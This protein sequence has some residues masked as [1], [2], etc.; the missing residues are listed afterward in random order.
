MPS[1]LITNQFIA[2]RT[3]SELHALTLARLFEG[4][5]WDVT[6][7]TLLY[8]YPLQGEFEAA[9]IR[10][11]T[12]G[13][14]ELLA[15]HYDVLFAQHRLAAE[16]VWNIGRISFGKVIV[17]VLGYL[18][19]AEQPPSFWQEADGFV[20]V[21]EETR[22]HV[23]AEYSLE[24]VPEM[25]FP[26]YAPAEY[27]DVTRKL[28]PSPQ[29]VCA[30]S[31][32]PPQELRELVAYARDRNVQID[33]FGYE[34]TS[35]EVTPGL[36][37]G[38]DAV[39]SIGR[40]AQPC[41]AT[42]VPFYCYDQFGGPGYITPDNLSR[43][44]YN[45]F[46]GRS[47][48]TK[49]DAAAL[50][51]D[52]IAGYPEAA[53]CAQRLRDIAR[54]A[55]DLDALFGRLLAFIDGVASSPASHQRA[56]APYETL[57]ADYRSCFAFLDVMRQF[58]GKGQLYFSDETG[59]LSEDNSWS[60]L[61]RYN[62]KICI[63]PRRESM[64]PLL[65]ARFDP[66]M[67]P[68]ACKILSGECSP[69][70]AVARIGEEDVFFTDDPSYHLSS[71]GIVSFSARPLNE[72]LLRRL[73]SQEVSQEASQRQGGNSSQGVG[74]MLSAALKKALGRQEEGSPNKR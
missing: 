9:G 57:S 19:D 44:A 24:G 35:V 74:G 16:H 42:G 13:S 52:L 56:A 7:F 51:S 32:H 22:D 60:F 17:S 59:A 70:N 69:L 50:F 62:S 61:Y 53:S 68:C 33:L 49:R 34:T 64:A 67:A 3:G 20:F 71:D 58:F 26:N 63:A 4:A 54:D 41:L 37:A 40:T 66:D 21:S 48:Q 28:P 39:I 14:E 46:S 6:C 2:A 43:H 25:V 45:N 38:Y 55:Y 8:G 47:E 11:I 27:F 23:R 10:V 31:N 73:I 12:L 72:A 1:V 5:G 36:I 30:L 15:N 18:A 65:P 29:T